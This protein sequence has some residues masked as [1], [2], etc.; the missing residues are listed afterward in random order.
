MG[1]V[2]FSFKMPVLLKKRSFDAGLVS[3]EESVSSV[4]HMI[5]YL[6]NNILMSW[7]IF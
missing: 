5:A 3:P 4:V 1:Y 2:S 6:K 7:F